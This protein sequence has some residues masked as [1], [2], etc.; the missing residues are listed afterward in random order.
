MAKKRQRKPTSLR[1]FANLA[2]VKVKLCGPGWG[3]RYGYTVPEWSGSMTCG[4]KTVT[5]AREHWA[6]STFGLSA[7][8]ALFT[9]LNHVYTPP[10]EET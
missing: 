2:K 6:V 1:T 9:M 7:A 10:K 4:F 8:L 3:G 5:E